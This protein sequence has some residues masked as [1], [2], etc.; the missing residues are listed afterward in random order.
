MNIKSLYSYLDVSSV[1]F[2]EGNTLIFMLCD[3][4]GIKVTHWK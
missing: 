3:T 4:C 1:N 2:F